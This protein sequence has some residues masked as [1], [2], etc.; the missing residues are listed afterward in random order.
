MCND[1]FWNSW[2]LGLH[3]FTYI[4]IMFNRGEF[5]LSLK[6]LKILLI[7]R[8]LNVIFGVLFLKRISVIALYTRLLVRY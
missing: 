7:F 1:C 4:V 3:R 8:D 2:L 6:K 5:E